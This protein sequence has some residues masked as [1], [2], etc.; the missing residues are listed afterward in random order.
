MI[1]AYKFTLD[2]VDTQEKQ[3]ILRE[4]QARIYDDD[5]QLT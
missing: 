4:I 3:P 5:F 1:E 2:L